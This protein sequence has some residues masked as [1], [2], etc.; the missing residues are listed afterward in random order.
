M[1]YRSIYYDNVKALLILLVVVGHFIEPYRGVY[2]HSTALYAFIYLF[3][4]P[5]FA[6]VSGRFSKFDYSTKSVRKVIVYL[7]VPYFLLQLGFSVFNNWM[8]GSELLNLQMFQPYWHLW[9][10]L[11]LILWTFLLPVVKLFR[12]PLLLALL[13]GLLVGLN[14]YSYNLSFSRTFVFF[15]FFILGHMDVIDR[16]RQKRIVW[17]RILAGI[18]LVGAFIVLLKMDLKTFNYYWFYGSVPYSLMSA[19]WHEGM[20]YRLYTYSASLLL[21]ISFLI[22]IP[23]RKNIFTNL[24]TKTF[25]VYVLHAIVVKVFQK[26]VD[27]Y[28]FVDP[29]YIC[30]LPV[31]ALATIVIL[32][33]PGLNTFLDLFLLK[34][35]TPYFLGNKKE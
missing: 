13:C 34:R 24:G 35:I 12:W 17:I 9:Y 19:N 15:P 8:S 10:L 20:L 30:T 23:E 25:V 4:V 6:Y 3:H 28:L 14:D 29:W 2:S 5:L 18:I 22:I 11:S 31:I 27:L 32:A 33:L 26:Y 16:I 1:N 7:I 21:L